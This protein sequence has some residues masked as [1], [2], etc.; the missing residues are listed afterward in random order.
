MPEAQ[1]R[2][3]LDLDVVR[4]SDHIWECEALEPEYL[5]KQLRGAIE[6][7]MNMEIFHAAVAKE[8]EDSKIIHETRNEIARGF[9]DEASSTGHES[10]GIVGAENQMPSLEKS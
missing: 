4:G 7:N 3:L 1:D 6:A 9:L 2:A 10:V 8:I 5:R